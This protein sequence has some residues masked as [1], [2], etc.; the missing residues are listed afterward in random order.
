MLKVTLLGVRT[1]RLDL[2][3][4]TV[5]AP[6]DA[7]S[8]TLTNLTSNQSTDITAV[9]W[10]SNTDSWLNTV[11]PLGVDGEQGPQGRFLI[12]IFRRFSGA[13]TN[14]TGGSY[15]ADT[16]VLTPPADWFLDANDASGADTLYVADTTICLLYTS[17]SPRDS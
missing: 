1:F 14:P 8:L 7:I 10:S 13:P 5:L 17:P 12:R 15:N 3:A 11:Y 6:G 9:R 4:D 2:G 16:G